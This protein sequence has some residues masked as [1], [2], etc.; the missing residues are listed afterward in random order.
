MVSY[1]LARALARRPDRC[2]ASSSEIQRTLNIK[3]RILEYI[4]Y[5][6]CIITPSFFI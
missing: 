2:N 6:I 4:G 3:D 5:V 1:R